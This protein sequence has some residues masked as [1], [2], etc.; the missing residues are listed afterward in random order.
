V[1]LALP[2]S[3]RRYEPLPHTCTR[4]SYR[5]IAVVS[6]SVLVGHCSVAHDET[7]NQF[8]LRGLTCSDKLVSTPS[9]PI[10]PGPHLQRLSSILRP[11]PHP[12]ST[13]D[14][15]SGQPAPAPARTPASCD[16]MFCHECADEWYRDEHGLTCPECGSDF[17]EIVS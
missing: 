4:L 1:F 7:L 17:T 8:L 2:E 16:M 14:P 13:M 6:H 3:P 10:A 5:P 11:T 12:H 9:F 15:S